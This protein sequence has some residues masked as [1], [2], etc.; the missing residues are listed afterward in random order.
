MR[1]LRQYP[2]FLIKEEIIIMSVQFR[3]EKKSVN[4]STVHNIGRI[5]AG[6]II[7]AHL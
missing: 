6:D 3:D 5:A 7:N 4:I 1:R 2:K